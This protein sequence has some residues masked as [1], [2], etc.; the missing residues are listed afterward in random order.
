YPLFPYT[1]L[2]RSSRVGL[3]DG[4]RSPSFYLSRPTKCWP[5]IP[6]SHGSSG[7]LR[8]PWAS[9]RLLPDV[10][11]PQRRVRGDPLAH[12]LD[13]ALVGQVDHAYAGLAQPVQAAREVHRLADHQRADAELPH[14]SAAV[15][16]RRQR[17]DHDGVPVGRLAAGL[18]EG[19]GLGVDRGITFLHPTV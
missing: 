17:G 14:Q 1:T 2:F 4:E 16:A 8:P 18:A 7:L 19:V 13:A 11:V 5:G 6:T 15:P 10:L 12:H 9:L 3:G